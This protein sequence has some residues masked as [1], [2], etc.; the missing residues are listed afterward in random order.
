MPVPLTE[1]TEAADSN[2]E[3]SNLDRTGELTLHRSNELKANS[4]SLATSC[5]KPVALEWTDSDAEVA[6]IQFFNTKYQISAIK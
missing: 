3:A 5:R 1:Y 4:A 2:S 6:T